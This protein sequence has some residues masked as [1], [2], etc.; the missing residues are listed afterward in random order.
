MASMALCVTVSS[1]IYALGNETTLSSTPLTT[2]PGNTTYIRSTEGLLDAIAQMRAQGGVIIMEDGDYAG[3]KV[4]LSY[5]GTAE[6]P[7]VIKA[8]NIGR[9]FFTGQTAIK[10]TGRYITLSGLNFERGFSVKKNSPLIDVAGVRN[11]LANSYFSNSNDNTPAPWVRLRGMRNQIDHNSFVG[12]IS[13]GSYIN[14]DIYSRFSSY[15]KITYNYFTRE[16][17]GQNGG[18]AIRVGHGKMRLYRGRVIIENNLF[19]NQNGESEV[20]SIKSS[21]N[22]IRNNTFN[23]SKGVLSLRQGNRSLVYDNY[24]VGSGAGK[25]EG[26]MVRGKGHIVFNNY[27]HDLNPRTNKGFEGAISLGAASATEEAERVQRGLSG[28]HF[29]LTRHVIV[30]GNSVVGSGSY[31]VVLNANYN[32]RNRLILPNWIRVINNQVFDS[33]I[34]PVLEGDGVQNNTLMNNQL[35]HPTNTS[36]EG[37]FCTR[38]LLVSGASSGFV[39]A[40]PVQK[41]DLEKWINELGLDM[42]WSENTKLLKRLR[43]T[44]LDPSVRIGFCPFNEKDE[45][46]VSR[47]FK[48]DVGPMQEEDSAGSL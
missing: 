5:L 2:N 47:L 45:K 23:S 27:F 34:K 1:M 35:E 9:V 37:I 30:A 29:P 15:H 14:V 22:I 4:T 17:L 28:R 31:G 41:E 11:V 32:S 21:E 33:G 6:A 13:A 24:F 16:P 39:P 38:S 36:R 19:D 48:S 8:K 12:K 42:K 25:H 44:L 10:V 3:V 7:L 46:T 18:S 43:E 26:L 20:V 40:K